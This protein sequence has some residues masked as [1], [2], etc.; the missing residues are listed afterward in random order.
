M[1]DR[2]KINNTNSL[3]FSSLQN[4]SK[5]IVANVAIG[6]RGDSSDMRMVR[7]LDFPENVWGTEQRDSA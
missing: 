3:Y 6:E 2:L 7:P 1:Y 5:E 4:L